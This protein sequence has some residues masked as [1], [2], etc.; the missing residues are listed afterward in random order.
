M[1]VTQPTTD[2]F[3]PLP[4]GAI[5]PQGWL[6]RQLE[7]QAAGLSGH[8]DE[9]WPDVAR[10][11]WI[12]G[13]RDGWERGPYWLDGLVPLA[14]LLGDERLI[15]KADHWV[16][17]ILAR[18]HDD[19][20]LGSTNDVRITGSGGIN[21]AHDYDPW[22]RFVVLKALTQYQEATGDT[23]IVP[24]MQRFLRR[25]AEV[26]AERPL[27]S[28][29]RYRWA[30]LVVSILWLHER[31]GEDWLLDLAATARD[32][33]FNWPAYHATF[34][35]RGRALPE[36]RDL[37][38]HVVNNAMGL[39]DP[40][41]RYRLDGDPAHR[42]AVAASIDTL[43]RWHGQA[44]GVFS[45]DEHL[46]GWNPSQGTELCAVVEYLYSLETLLPI[47]GEASLGDRFERIAYNALPATISADMWTH[48]YVQQVN[49]AVC[50]VNEDR[51]YTSNGPDANI[52]GLEPHFG[53]C[54]ANMHQGWP[55]V[56]SHLWLRSSDDGLAAVSYAPCVVTTEVRGVPVRIAVESG[57]P[58]DGRVSITVEAAE[59]ARF[60]V[61]LR[62]PGWAEGA[63]LAVGTDVTPLAT[64]EFHEVEREWSGS[65]VLTMDLP[66]QV[67]IER[68][69]GGS[70][71]IHRGPL[72]LAHP[73]GEEWRKVAGED[74]H[75]DWEVY[76][77]T[78]WNHALVLPE[79][80]PA[81]AIEIGTGPVGDIP[82]GPDAPPVTGSV[83]GVP[84]AGWEIA[85]N[86][87][88]P[89]PTSPVEATGTASPLRLVPYGSTTLRIAQFPV[90]E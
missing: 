62:V 55:K 18:Q 27:R 46:A 69:E 15:A 4:L 43:D 78:A 16:N 11:A 19:G 51:V 68:R 30:D 77:T 61:R 50:A 72:L 73:I 60:P 87:A 84:V 83:P 56:A 42:A 70:A 81:A 86:A 47:L 74:P 67:R 75:A 28:W 85:H 17:A 34:S 12:G 66:M 25:L 39:K 40:G 41:I 57:Y 20:W 44:T 76:P 90:V 80:E 82:F 1:T 45:G 8:L 23:R 2:P 79:D 32:Q 33:G 48:Q 89:V 7:I 24:A 6:L 3:A 22:P 58:F 9:F 49:Q 26:L 53:C 59:T 14:F 31:T 10:S 71:A 37:S 38:T 52:F 88:G 64:G 35:I 65:T 36:E 5:R 29:G 63:T 54:T 13:D 21:L